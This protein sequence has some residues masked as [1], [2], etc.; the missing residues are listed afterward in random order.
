MMKNRLIRTLD[1]ALDLG[2]S[3]D[4][5]LSPTHIPSSSGGSNPNALFSSAG[6]PLTLPSYPAALQAGT[7]EREDERRIF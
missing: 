2:S 6:G 3:F 1:K 7:G 5:I 4:S